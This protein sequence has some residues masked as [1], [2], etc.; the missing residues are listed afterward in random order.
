MVSKNCFQGLPLK[1]QGASFGTIIIFLSKFFI[2]SFTGSEPE[3]SIIINLCRVFG[4]HLTHTTCFS[5]SMVTLIWDILVMAINYQK[6][7]RASSRKKAQVLNIFSSKDI[8]LWYYLKKYLPI[9]HEKIYNLTI[10][11][12]RALILNC[13]LY[14]SMVNENSVWNIEWYTNWYWWHIWRRSIENLL[15]N[16]IQI[17]RVR[18]IVSKL[19]FAVDENDIEASCRASNRIPHDPNSSLVQTIFPCVHILFRQIKFFTN[20]KRNMKWIDDEYFISQSWSA[21]WEM[22]FEK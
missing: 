4:P 21:V 8:Y 9:F 6:K 2:G 20:K 7:V 11:F 19:F 3:M 15:L 13:Q 17:P 5:W 10:I 16:Q 14:N 12:C 18:V 1:F 22:Q